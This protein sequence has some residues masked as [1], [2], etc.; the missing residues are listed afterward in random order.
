MWQGFEQR[1]LARLA[2][3]RSCRR[4]GRLSAIRG[5]VL[6]ASGLDV[7]L[8]ELVDILPLQGGASLVAEVVGLQQEHALLMPYGT[9]DGLSLASEVVARGEAYSVPVGEA[10]LGRVLDATC[11]PLDD[12]PLPDDLERLPRLVAPINPLHRAPIDTA[13]ATGV[14]AVDLFM[15]LGR[16]Q[17]MG[18]FAGSGVGKSTLLG[19]MSQHTEADVIVIALIGERGREVGD[20]IRDSLGERGLEKAVVIAAAAEQPAV[21]RRQAAYTA[22]TIAEWF[23]AQGKQVLLIMD[24]ITRFALAQREIG[25]ATGEPMGSRGYPPSV[26]ALLPPLMERAGNLRDQGSITGVYTVLV[27]GDDM[28]EPVADH[29]RAILDGHIVL[30]RNIGARGH[31]PAIDVL[32]S[33]SRLAGALRS[34]EQKRTVDAVRSAMGVY[35]NS[36]DLIELGAYEKGSQ[37][38]IDL[39]IELKPELDALLQQTPDE[40]C[41]TD[42]AW[43]ALQRLAQRL[44]RGNAHAA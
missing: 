35:R 22:T 3:T 6:E 1:A 44:T 12:R 38:L 9:V 43:Q 27:E 26:L 10:L 28:N 18:I 4:T 21:L 20:F 31:W 8:G 37:R 16:G 42:K 40:H 14:K 39:M 33:I 13:L 19:M 36:E 29:M 30:D 11:Q 15:P 7:R 32:N 5:M 17:R 41:P 2:E 25:L 23:R 34:G 24:S